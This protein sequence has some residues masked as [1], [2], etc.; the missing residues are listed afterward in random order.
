MKIPSDLNIP[1]LT[2]LSWDLVKSIP[3]DDG[4]S[5]SFGFSSTDDFPFSWR[6]CG[7]KLMIQKQMHI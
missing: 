1:S 2:S 5:E 6:L 4:T 7:W 3:D